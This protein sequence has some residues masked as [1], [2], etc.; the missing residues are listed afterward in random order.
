MTKT[1]VGYN[2]ILKMYEEGIVTSSS[3]NINQMIDIVNELRNSSN[4]VAFKY[5]KEE[6]EQ[7]AYDLNLEAEL[8]KTN[9]KW[10]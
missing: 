7:L 2:T 10:K 5:E 1:N 6:F 3:P 4:I 8:E 9:I